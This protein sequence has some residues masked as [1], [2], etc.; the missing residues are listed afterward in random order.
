MNCRYWYSVPVTFKKDSFYDRFDD[1]TLAEMLQK[2]TVLESIK[3]R[4]DVFLVPSLIN[5]LRGRNVYIRSGLKEKKHEIK[6]CKICFA[7]Q[8]REYGF[9][10]FRLPWLYE[11]ANCDIHSI[12]LDII[13]CSGCNKTLKGINALT[14]ALRGSCYN[15]ATS[16]YEYNVKDRCASIP[17]I[18]NIN[19]PPPIAHCFI[20]ELK[21]LF[22][23]LQKRAIKHIKK[24]E[25]FNSLIFWERKALLFDFFP[26]QGRFIHDSFDYSKVLNI[27]F[28][29]NDEK[30]LNC[31]RGL[32]IKRNVTFKNVDI[33]QETIV[34]KHSDCKTCLFQK[35]CRY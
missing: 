15:C 10:W 28:S 9:S 5:L 22:R 29:G 16:L 26:K 1:D 2:H 34:G 25:D 3:S 7:T 33:V 6:Y 14:S 12:K 13:F 32:W 18:I 8:I 20:L 31:F 24:H 30:L 27:V 19:C 17:K 23:T 4:S 35:G 21:K 11:N